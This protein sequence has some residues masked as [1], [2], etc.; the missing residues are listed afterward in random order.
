MRVCVVIYL[1]PLVEVSH[2]RVP[3]GTFYPVEAET[4]EVVFGTNMCSHT[5]CWTDTPSPHK[6]LH[7]IPS[8]FS[9]PLFSSLYCPIKPKHLKNN[10]CHLSKELHYIYGLLIVLC[11][12]PGSIAVVSELAQCLFFPSRRERRT[13]RLT[14]GVI[15]LVFIWA[16]ALTGLYF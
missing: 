2:C 5:H 1:Q 11:V 9:S 13:A 15:A 14:A 16:G 12:I 3:E 6:Q 4:V 10:R 7:A 8:H